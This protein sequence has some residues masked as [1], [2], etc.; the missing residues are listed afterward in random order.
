MDTKNIRQYLSNIYENY[1]ID[2]KEHVNTTTTYKAKCLGA[3]EALL[4]V[5][6]TLNAGTPFQYQ[7]KTKIVKLFWIFPFTYKKSE[8]YP[9]H[10]LRLTKETLNR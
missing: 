6:G 1:L 2:T 8:S 3:M 5:L 4:V 10:I 7:E 9:E